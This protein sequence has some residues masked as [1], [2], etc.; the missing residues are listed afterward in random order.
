MELKE[1]NKFTPALPELIKSL[2]GRKLRKKQQEIE[3]LKLEIIKAKL[4]K[5]LKALED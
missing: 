1:E 4:Q 3:E 2:K 5:E